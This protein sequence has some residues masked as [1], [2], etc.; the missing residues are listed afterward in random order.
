MTG[1]FSGLLAGVVPNVL[2]GWE[3]APKTDVGGGPKAESVTVPDCEFPDPRV[4]GCPNAGVCCGLPNTDGVG[5]EGWPKAGVVAG[6]C[7]PKAE[8][9]VFWVGPK[10]EVEG[11]VGVLPNTD[12][13]V[14][15]GAPKTD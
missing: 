12:V 2:V 7:V 4:D 5:F 13:V 3:G 9:V 6:F 15:V 14:L 11:F 8:V 1:G 10:T